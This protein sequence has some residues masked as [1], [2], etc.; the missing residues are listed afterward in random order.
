MTRLPALLVSDNL[1]QGYVDTSNNDFMC[2]SP[3]DVLELYTANRVQE[4][5]KNNESFSIILHN[6]Q[7]KMATLFDIVDYYK[8]SLIQMFYAAT[9]ERPAQ[10][11]LV[12]RPYGTF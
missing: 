5:F 1:V 11:V 7:N 9:N 8:T 4:C 6:V 10:R 12:R 3:K 2:I